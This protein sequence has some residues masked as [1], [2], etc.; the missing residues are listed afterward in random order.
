MKKKSQFTTISIPTPL[1]DKIKKKINGTGI[2]SPSAYVTFILRE[3]FSE[4]DTK[5]DNQG[6]TEIK[7][8]L[9]NLGYL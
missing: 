2:H 9:K 5:T 1:V 7:Q 8:R 4:A 6:T 3:I